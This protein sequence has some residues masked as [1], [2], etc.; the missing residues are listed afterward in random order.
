MKKIEIGGYRVLIESKRERKKIA[1]KAAQIK[2]ERAQEKIKWAVKELQAEGKKIT[3][4]RVAKK[5]GVSYN[6]AKKYLS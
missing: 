5:A 3:P 2:S 1:Q 6:T 4:Y